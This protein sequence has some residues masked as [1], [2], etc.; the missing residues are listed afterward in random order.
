MFSEK[1]YTQ[2]MENLKR[3]TVPAVVSGLLVA[4]QVLTP[5]AALAEEAQ[6]EELET[7]APIEQVVEAPEEESQ[8][9]AVQEEAP[10]EEVQEIQ[11]EASVEEA[12]ETVQN[13]TTEVAPEETQETIG[14]T[15]I[16]QA[17]GVVEAQAETPDVLGAR[18]TTP[19]VAEVHSL[20]PIQTQTTPSSLAAQL[21]PAVTT[22][23]DTTYVSHHYTENLTTEKFISSIGEEARQ[24]AQENDL[25]ASVMIAQAILESNSGQSGLAKTPNNN[26]FGIKGVWTDEEGQTHAVQMATMEDDGE[27][28]LVQIMA[29]FRAYDTTSD[30]LR[31]YA[32]L[33]H[34]TDTGM[35]KFY[36][37]TWK[38]NTNSYVD[39][40]NYLQGRYAT[41]TSYSAKLQSL[42]ETY[43]LTRF[44]D[45]LG[46]EIKGTIYDPENEVSNEDGYRD[47]TMDDYIKLESVATSL[48]GT[49]YVWGGSTPENGLDCSGLTSYVYKEALGIDISRTTYTQQ[50]RGQAV[51]F[52]D[53]R[54]GDLLFFEKD[55]DVH[56]V[57]MYL[58]D[59][60]YIHAPHEGDEVKI[61]SMDEYMPTFARRIVNFQVV[62]NQ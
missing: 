38:S 29:N 14:A 34:N 60:N 62:E 33:L 47:L 17:F 12:P 58:G 5:V 53:L 21:I 42:I 56:H 9:T 50:Y 24:I 44:D 32:N 25:Y 61:T 15:P 30:S 51:D 46:Y 16:E 57:A 20:D 48:L 41:D 23:Q 54:M 3:R 45:P 36:S 13:E 43:N 59:G 19:T 7:P 2:V 49:K 6:I 37:P 11:P 39:A 27:G 52:K 1:K 35:G 10:Q 8:E 55:G 4:S 22:K 31:D 28:N 26:L 40:C 18:R